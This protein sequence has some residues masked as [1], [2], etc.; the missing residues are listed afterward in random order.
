VTPLE[1]DDYLK[2]ILLTIT[3]VLAT[4]ITSVNADTQQLFNS[5]V[6]V[7]NLN[8]YTIT[9]PIDISG[10]TNVE[11]QVEISVVSGGTISAYVMDAAS[12]QQFQ[13]STQP[14][15]SALYRAD[16]IVSQTMSVPIAKSGNYYVVLD[17]E[18]SLLTSKTVKVQLSLSFE[19]PFTSS[20]QFYVIVVVVV[21]A[22]A[23]AFIFVFVRRKRRVRTRIPSPMRNLVMTE[24]GFK[25][26]TF[27]GAMMHELARTCPACGKQQS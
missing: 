15:Q 9:Q 8:Y 20:T 23:A 6:D 22:V 26:C 7:K 2:L 21:L 13:Q 5:T 1:K 27:C 12:Y 3:L 19:P 25:K 16:D 4:Q 18:K 24:V 11:L 10:M 14:P 17:N